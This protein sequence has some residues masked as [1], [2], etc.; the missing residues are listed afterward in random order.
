ME[1]LFVGGYAHIQK[2]G[3]IIFGARC[4]RRLMSLDHLFEQKIEEISI[5]A[6]LI[7]YF[8][9]HPIHILQFFWH[10]KNM[11]TLRSKKICASCA[12]KKYAHLVRV[13]NDN[14][15]ISSG[16]FCQT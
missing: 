9:Q 1:A 8:S 5:Y 13:K 6:Q 11:R 10:A 14:I 3:I 4:S 7:Y 12:S 15:S 16:K 2:Y